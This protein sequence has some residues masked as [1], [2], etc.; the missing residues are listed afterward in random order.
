[1]KKFQAIT[2]K[3]MRKKNPL[4]SQTIFTSLSMFYLGKMKSN[5]KLANVR[6]LD[7]TRLAPQAHEY[8]M[9]ITIEL[10]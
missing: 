4:I 5:A 9:R 10:Q 1:M 3:I 6:Q 7:L 8:G 2:G